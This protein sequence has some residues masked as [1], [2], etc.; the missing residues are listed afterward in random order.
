MYEKMPKFI[1][2]KIW[3]TSSV[4]EH[5]EYLKWLSRVEKRAII[6][7][8]WI[9]LATTLFI[10]LW[11]TSWLLP[12][13]G[14]FALFLLYAMSN[15]ALSYFFYFNRIVL[16]QVKGV[17]YASYFADIVFITA[18]VYLDTTLQFGVAMQND[19][20]ILY[21]LLIM[22]GFAL[23]RT[24]AENMFMSALIALLFVLALSLQKSTFSFMVERSFVL[25][26]MLIWMVALMSWFI[27]EI[28]NQQ[29][30][31][32]IK[33]K[34]RLMNTQHLTHLGE[35]AAT[36]A[37][38]VN[39]PIGI[40][41]A[42]SEYLL[43]QT[44]PDDPHREDYEAIR[45]E[46]LRCEKIVGELLT[47]AKPIAQEI[48]QCQLERINDEVLDLLFRTEDNKIVIKREYDK[49]LPSLIADPAQLKQA[50][51][52]VYI[53]ARDAIEG[54]G[55]IESIIRFIKDSD[56]KADTDFLS[57]MV[58]DSGKGFT[59]EELQR[60]FDPFY[61]TRTGGT[62]LGLTITRQ[63]V[64]AHQGTISLGNLSSGGA[65]VAINLPVSV[66]IKNSRD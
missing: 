7:L 61:T 4:D 29:K 18:L 32:V 2:G 33:I 12:S 50:L 16:S 39:N 22:R 48:R 49:N 52:N 34:E 14:I 43:R 64:E 13:P 28:I 66:P 6:P 56:T 10:W 40:I 46:A 37:H 59:R 8:K 19:F 42:Y 20:Y 45:R 21:F 31:E 44:S 15:V 58:R 26:F 9:I 65:E 35:I 41:T 11:G 24:P 62:G 60:A 47:Y 38:E 5:Q 51:L 23:F 1:N 30:S 55:I 36:V 54:D 25:K 27:V 63:I 53:N 3:Q 17:C 57:L